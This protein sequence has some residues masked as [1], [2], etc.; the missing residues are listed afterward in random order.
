MGT[1]PH[2]DSILRLNLVTR[3]HKKASE[4]PE[5]ST[6]KSSKQ[7]FEAFESVRTAVAHRRVPILPRMSMSWSRR[8][9]RSTTVVPDQTSGSFEPLLDVFSRTTCVP[10]RG[11]QA[12]AG[13]PPR[14]TGL[15]AS[16]RT[17][18]GEDSTA[19]E[20]EVQTGETAKTCPGSDE[21]A[22]RT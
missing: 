15:H 20:K 1:H 10:F 8:R 21:R 12:L 16:C 5:N 2:H 9:S 18:S 11:E 17:P 7:H 4:A 22:T 13:F 6:T 3:G 19:Q 14:R